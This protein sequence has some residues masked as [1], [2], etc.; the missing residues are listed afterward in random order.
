MEFIN[1]FTFW[2][3]AGENIEVLLSKPILVISF[4]LIDCSHQVIC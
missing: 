4:S 3:G 2:G 1:I